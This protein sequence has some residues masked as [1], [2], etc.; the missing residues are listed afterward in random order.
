MQAAPFQLILCHILHLIL[1]ARN[2]ST[3]HPKNIH[4]KFSSGKQPDLPSIPAVLMSMAS[5]NPYIPSGT[6]FLPLQLPSHNLPFPSQIHGFSRSWLYLRPVAYAALLFPSWHIP[7]PDLCQKRICD[8]RI[9]SR[10]PDSGCVLA[11]HR[12][13]THMIFV[14]PHILWQSVD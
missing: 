14:C 9:T 1:P 11:N 5:Y 12:P 10:L 6:I 7:L 4:H 8:C 2:P 3:A 13:M